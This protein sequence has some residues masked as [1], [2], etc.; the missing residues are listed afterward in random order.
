MRREMQK[1]LEADGDKLRALTGEDHG[2]FS[3]DDLF[4]TEPCKFCRGTGYQIHGEC[5]ECEG[6]GRQIAGEHGS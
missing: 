4:L 5:E 3:L 1:A 2:P 6:I